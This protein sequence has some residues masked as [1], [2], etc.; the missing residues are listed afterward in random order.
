MI[1]NTSARDL[2]QTWA[3]TSGCLVKRLARGPSVDREAAEAWAA[4]QPWSGR[5]VRMG[6]DARF[7]VWWVR[8]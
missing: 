4:K 5:V 3:T 6:H 8:P 7:W 1:S 2:Q